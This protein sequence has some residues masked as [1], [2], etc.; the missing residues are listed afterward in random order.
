MDHRDDW[1]VHLQRFVKGALERGADHEFT[2]N[3][4]KEITLIDN[5][6]LKGMEFLTLT[7]PEKE[8]IDFKSLMNTCVLG[9]LNQAL[10]DIFMSSRWYSDF[11]NGVEIPKGNSRFGGHEMSN[12]LIAITAS[13]VMSCVVS[14]SFHG[15]AKGHLLHIH[16]IVGK[17]DAH[18]IEFLKNLHFKSWFNP[19]QKIWYMVSEAEMRLRVAQIPGL[20][21]DVLRYIADSSQREGG[22]Q[23]RSRNNFSL[24]EVFSMLSNIKHRPYKATGTCMRCRRHIPYVT[25]V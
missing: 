16:V 19:S 5:D 20:P 13:C 7:V 23:T 11:N 2:T 8:L 14:L 22:H 6:K 15:T 25:S 4:R 9:P 12:G 10:A 21:D 17:R 1:K 18:A 24:H 3:K